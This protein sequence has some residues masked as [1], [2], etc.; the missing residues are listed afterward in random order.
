MRRI[1]DVPTNVPA[2]VPGEAPVFG[3]L[4]PPV[5]WRSGRR[6]NAAPSYL[7]GSPAGWR[8]QWRPPRGARFEKTRPTPSNSCIIRRW[9]GPARRRDAEHTA[10]QLAT[11]CRTIWIAGSRGGHHLV[12]NATSR[13]GS[14]LLA[15]IVDACHTAIDKAL[16]APQEALGLAEGLSGTLATL[17]L[18]AGEVAKG[19]DGIP[20]VT[21]NAESLV[22]DALA[23]VLS[24]AVDADAARAA[25]AN[26]DA[27]LPRAPS[28]S[29]PSGPAYDADGGAPSLGR[30]PTFGE[31]SQS[32]ID[33]RIE[34]DG[35]HHKDIGYL[36]LRRKTFIDIVG[37][38]PVDRYRPL[39]LQTY[40]SE[41][42]YW[43]ANQT[44]RKEF[45]GLD[46][47]EILEANR[48]RH[49]VPLSQKT[50]QDGYVANV[51]TMMRWG[52]QSHAYADP[53]AGVR[54]RYP[55]MLVPSSIREGLSAEI[56]NRVFAEGVRSGY[57]DLAM[58]PILALVTSRRLGLLLY[59]RGSDIR[60]KD[61]VWIAQTSG[62]IVQDDAPAELV[63]FKTRESTSYFVL[64][65]FF[66]KIGFI[67][68]AR[69]RPGFIFEAAHIP[70]D[71]AGA[72]SK[73]LNRLL[74][75]C[76]AIGDNKEVFH[77]FRHAA[78]DAN[79]DSALK[80]RSVRLQ[81]GHETGADTHEGYGRKELLSS[82]RELIAKMALPSEID[83]SVFNKLDFDRLAAK[84]RPAKNLKR[85]RNL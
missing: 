17:R 35:E 47:R 77:C 23:G 46:T 74:V 19:D 62:L 44:K 65:E 3:P 69:K 82:E 79:R 68:W 18:V 12:Q 37:D 6:K 41:M 22:R 43:P 29:R 38:R 67:E 39:D 1:D 84:R 83:W 53:F 49:L 28:S 4:E 14:D 31:V 24:H 78:I 81:A 32:Y 7:T 70:K 15:A 57:L 36:R 50:L 58:L 71:P 59:L 72:A 5:D 16:A 64:H 13:D 56:I 33:M 20:A 75:K 34:S 30:M 51:K 66:E 2:D 54:L 10:R 85:K 42:Q 45:S 40:V 9:I 21:R 25:I 76:G 8:F 48:D 55:K 60:R 61:G 11:L 80:P 26:V 73:N 27:I 63:P 52:M